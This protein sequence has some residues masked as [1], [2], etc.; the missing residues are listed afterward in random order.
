[1]SVARVT[2]GFDAIHDNVATKA[3]IAEVKADLRAAEQRLDA[4]IDALRANLD[5]VEHRLMTRLGGMI[6]AATGILIAIRCFG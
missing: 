2:R 3:D 1:M 4:R 5:F 6:V